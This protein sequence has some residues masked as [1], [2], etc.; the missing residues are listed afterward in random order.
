[1]LSNCER[2]QKASSFGLGCILPSNCGVGEIRPVE[3]GNAIHETAKGDESDVHFANYPPD[4]C[5]GV[6]VNDGV[7]ASRVGFVVMFRIALVV[8]G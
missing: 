2:L 5:L 3:Q 6:A 7:V 4:F 1:M 8:I